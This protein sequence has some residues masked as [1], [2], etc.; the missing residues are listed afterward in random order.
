MLP[1]AS[2]TTYVRV[3]T[4]GH[5]PVLSAL[6][7]TVK[8]SSAVHASAIIKSPKPSIAETVVTAA[9]ASLASQ[10]ATVLSVIDPVTTG[11][12]VSSTIIVCIISA[13]VLPQASCTTYVR[14]ITNGHMPAVSSVLVTVSSTHASVINK[15]SSNSTNPD[16]V[17]CAGASLAS[18][19]STMLSSIDPVTVS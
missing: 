4:N 13:V 12:V 19:P 18:Q 14:V 1:Q 16:T 11:A 17:V 10:P 6:L 9:G 7:V 8:S 5:V 3:I 2:C 15:S